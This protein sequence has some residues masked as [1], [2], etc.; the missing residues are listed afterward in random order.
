MNIIHKTFLGIFS[1]KSPF[2]IQEILSKFAFDIKLPQK[3]LDSTTGKTTWAYSTSSHKFITQ[4]N[5]EEYDRT[6]GWN[7]KKQEVS[8]LNDIIRIWKKINFTTTE[9]Q[10]DCIN[11]AQCDPIYRTENAFRCTN[12]SDCKN[13]VFCDGCHKSEYLIACQRSSNCTFC[14]RVDDSNSCS[15]SYNVICS[16]KISNSFFIQDCNSLH[17]CMFCSHIANKR[18]CIAN[19][20]FEEEEYFAI[21]EQI[22]KWIL[23]GS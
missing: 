5:M 2:T 10:Y 21:K 4:T 6:N 14:I 13:I 8:D 19:M 16:S 12:C 9:R 1:Q 17:E 20:P 18:Y 11:V 22:I 3:V 7:L 23:S 15:N